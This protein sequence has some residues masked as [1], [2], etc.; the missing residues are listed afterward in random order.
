MRDIVVSF[1]SV[2]ERLM[3]F[4]ISLSPIGV[5]TYMSWV[6]ATQGVEILGSLALVILC[7]Y[8]AMWSMRWWCTPPPVRIFAGI[9][10]LR[11]SRVLPRP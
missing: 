1:Y 6:V 3:A 11:F 8:T 7:A 5:F 2:I 9:S 10:P 4:I